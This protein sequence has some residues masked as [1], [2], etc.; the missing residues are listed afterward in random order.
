MYR[1]IVSLVLIAAFAAPAMAED[2]SV[3]L[4]RAQ[5]DLATKGDAQAQ[6]YLAEMYEQGLGTA[7]DPQRALEWYRKAAD[8]GHALGQRKVKE[9]STRGAAARPKDVVPVSVAPPPPALPAPVPAKPAAMLD[10]T[11]QKAEE[12]EQA[13][14]QA[15]QA[16]LAKLHAE[17][18]AAAKKQKEAAAAAQKAKEAAELEQR[19][20]TAKAA[21]A[22]EKA[23]AKKFGTG[24]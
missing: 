20:A 5:L 14:A 18:Q 11:A 4:F 23:D 24:Y 7:S 9:L 10:E 21:L 1:Y 8:Q 17:Q 13:R 16:R 3:R 19:R 12:Q 2:V 15:E 22:R 6:F